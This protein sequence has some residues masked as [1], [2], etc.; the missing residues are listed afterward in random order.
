MNVYVVRYED[1][2]IE[3]CSFY[4]NKREAYNGRAKLRK[5]FR[6][7]KSGSVERINIGRKKDGFINLFHKYGIQSRLRD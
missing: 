2:E 7:F 1:A 4:C 6:K 3:Y 5:K